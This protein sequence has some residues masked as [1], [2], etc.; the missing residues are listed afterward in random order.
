MVLAIHNI[1]LKTIHP[2]LKKG[3]AYKAERVAQFLAAQSRV[4][5]QQSGSK[6]LCDSSIPV[7]CNVRNSELPM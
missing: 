7:V 6:P 3:P 2:A 4:N 5:G 1:T